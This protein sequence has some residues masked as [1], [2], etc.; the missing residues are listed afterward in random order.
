MQGANEEGLAITQ[1]YDNRDGLDDRDIEFRYEEAMLK[2]VVDSIDAAIEHVEARGPVTAGDVKAADIVQ[3]MQDTDLET[4]RAVRNRPYF[5]R[6]DYA[7]SDGVVKA[8]YIGDIGI[9]HHDPRYFIANRNTP[10]ARLYY[11]PGD[12]YYPTPGGTRSA[13]V[14]LKRTLT[15]IA[16]ELLDYDDV[17]RLPSGR[18]TTSRTPSRALY[19]KLLGLSTGQLTDAVQTI[20]PEQYEQI[21]ATQKPVLIVQG[22][23]G[24][25]K[26][27]I[28]L[29]RIDFILSPFSDIGNLGRHPTAERV[30]MFGPSPA[31]LKYVSALLPSLGVQRVKQTT[32]SQWMLGQFSSRVTLGRG[33]SIFGDLMNNRRRLTAA[34]VEAHSF[35]TSLKMKKLVDNYV[36]RVKRDILA[37]AGQS[38]GVSIPGSSRLEISKSNLKPRVSGAFRKNKEPN[39]ARDSLVTELAEEWAA[40]NPPPRGTIQL[41]AIA[42]ARIVVDRSLTFWPRSDFR[43]E[44]VNIMSSPETILEC[45]GKG[46]IDLAQAGEIAL[47]APTGAGQALGLTD[48]AAALYLD[49][50][51]NGFR[52]ERF[53]HIVV[54]EAQDVSPLEM[55][56]MQMN[57]ANDTFTILGDLRQGVLPYKSIGNWNQL[58]TLFKRE[59]VSRLESRVTF[60]STKQITRY[61]NRILQELPGRTKIPRPYDRNGDRPRLVRS[62][63]AAGMHSAITESVK[64][65]SSL[66][67][68]RSVAVLTKWRQTARDISRA[69]GDQ[70]VAEVAILSEGGVIETDLTVSSIILTKGLEFDAVIVANVRKDNFNDTEFD[71]LL[72]YLAC[73]RA[74]HHLELHWYGALSPIVPSVARL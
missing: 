65:L 41:N 20:Q 8:I 15:I 43:A 51:I 34:E 66:A 48:I 11:R 9:D 26:S 54:D 73:T 46:D 45:A 12:E 19:E 68:V 27:L 67:D 64:R 4:A 21:A 30:I 2:V 55:L 40:L 39:A 17:L 44:Y 32:V 33:D 74:R 36:V 60:R 5:G 24:S 59:N 52:S 42:A 28:G 72:L 23:A 56:L 69:L 50:A 35:K 63:S 53:E 6:V 58:A 13:F 47:T 22:A 18:A 25:G 57:S 49:Y 7:E 16:A 71:R 29:H 3:K 14:H 10:I 31:F 38:S 70:G 62:G 61:A 1:S 37:A